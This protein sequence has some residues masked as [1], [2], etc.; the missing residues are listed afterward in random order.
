MTTA[1]VVNT[2]FSLL[3]LS[4]STKQR[5]TELKLNFAGGTQIGG[6][7]LP[8]PGN[9]AQ[10]AMQRL[11]DRM[12]IVAP[13]PANDLLKAF[14]DPNSPL[15]AILADK[16][17]END[18]VNPKELLEKSK[19]N[20]NSIRS[21]TR[22]PNPLVRRLGVQALANTGDLTVA[23]VLIERLDDDDPSTYS[24]ALTG[25]RMLSRRHDSFGLPRDNPS[26]EQR[27]EGKKRWTEWFENLRMEVDPSQQFD[28]QDPKPNKVG[29][30][31]AAGDAKPADAAAKPADAA[32]KPAEKEE[33]K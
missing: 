24:L 22:H 18:T 16:K 31:P 15:A 28:F 27:A 11:S 33:K 32:A 20:L 9:I 3:F 4:R 2:A 30:K 6:E 12:D 5:L 23:P 17:K 19:G 29:A 7:G 21:M 13:T 10:S 14:D 1:L 26:D 8:T 25:L